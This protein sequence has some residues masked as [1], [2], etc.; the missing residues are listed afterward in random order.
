MADRTRFHSKDTKSELRTILLYRLNTEGSMTSDSLFVLTQKLYQ[1]TKPNDDLYI[2]G[3]LFFPRRCLLYHRRLGFIIV[4]FRFIFFIV[5][6]FVR[7][8]SPSARKFSLLES[9]LESQYWSS[10][11]W[12]L[13]LYCDRVSL[14]FSLLRY[15]NHCMWFN[16]DFCCY[17]LC[18]FY[19]AP[20]CCS[21]RWN[22]NEL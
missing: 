2:L 4:M 18:S 17:F 11:C 6:N 19:R 22:S 13:K 16:T 5:V 15:Q 21:E 10:E 14:Y 7:V 20:T 9:S 3:K 1:S 8:F 12:K